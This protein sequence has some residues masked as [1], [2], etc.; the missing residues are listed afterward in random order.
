M[1]FTMYIFLMSFTGLVITGFTVYNVATTKEDLT[2]NDKYPIGVF[3]VIC[4][5]IEGLL[6]TF[7]CFEMTSECLEIV[8]T[9][10]TYVDDLKSHYPRPMSSWKI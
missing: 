7:F 6:F 3:L 1:N 5:A 2:K 10:Q 4:G 9:N 8:T